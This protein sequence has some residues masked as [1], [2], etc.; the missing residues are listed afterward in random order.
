MVLFAADQRPTASCRRSEIIMLPF[1]NRQTSFPPK[2]KVLSLQNLQFFYSRPVLRWLPYLFCLVL[3]V[4]LFGPYLVGYGR[5]TLPFSADPAEPEVLS[6]R[7]QMVRE[8]YVHAYSSYKRDAWTFDELK[9]ISGGSVN[10]YLNCLRISCP[11]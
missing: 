10:K 4:W 3:T 1:H 11:C 7:A 6:A 8:A 2:R 5:H 9:P